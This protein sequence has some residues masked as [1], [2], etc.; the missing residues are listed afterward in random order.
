VDA[1]ELDLDPGDEELVN[2]FAYVVRDLALERLDLT[3]PLT[4]IEADRRL[5]QAVPDGAVEFVPAHLLTPPIWSVHR[6]GRETVASSAT[7]S[8][9]AGYGVPARQAASLR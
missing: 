7:S 3:D 1:I 9:S 4:A 6:D 2:A 5:S 8:T